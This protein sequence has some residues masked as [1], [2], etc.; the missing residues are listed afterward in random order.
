MPRPGE[1]NGRDYHFY[2]E[3]DF[4]TKAEN[5]EFLEH[6][7]VHGNWYATPYEEIERIQEKGGIVVLKID[8]Q[9]AKEVVSR[10][11]DIQTVFI[12]PPSNEELERRIRGRGT[13]T[14]EAIAHRLRNAKAEI[15]TSHFYRHHVVNETIPE[16]VSW[17]ERLVAELA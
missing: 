2:T 6:K 8:V 7:L 1:Q 5:D 10:F 12:V 14:E 15:E 3:G 4:L 16:V 13:E 17:L 11:P 9:G